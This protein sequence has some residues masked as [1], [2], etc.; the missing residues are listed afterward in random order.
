MSESEWHRLA[1][2]LQP[3][4][5][6]HRVLKAVVFGSLARGDISRRSDVDLI[7]IRDTEERFLDRY[8]DLG[9][10]IVQAVPERD[11]DL[12]IYTP[13]ELVQMADRSFIATALREGRIIYESEQAAVSG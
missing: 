2:R 1:A 8:G 7:V 5:E 11:V 6:K 13:Q 12:L 3:I 9:R 10:E 4:F